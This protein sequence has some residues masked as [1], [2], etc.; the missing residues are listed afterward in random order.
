[1]IP[2]QDYRVEKSL[3]LKKNHIIRGSPEQLLNVLLRDTFYKK[4]KQL[5]CVDLNEWTKVSTSK[6]SI[7]EIIQ[8]FLIHTVSF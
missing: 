1:M 4:I 2:I 7:N 6:M 8:I 3:N 5:I